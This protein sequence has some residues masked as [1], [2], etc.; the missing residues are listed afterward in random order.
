[1]EGIERSQVPARVLGGIHVGR[2]SAG[3]MVRRVS[4]KDKLRYNF[5]HFGSPDIEGFIGS[6]SKYQAKISRQF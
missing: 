1:M 3:I 2:A 4:L 5:L 6:S